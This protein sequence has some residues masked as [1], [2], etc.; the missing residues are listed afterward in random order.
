MEENRSLTFSDQE[1]FDT[2]LTSF[3]SKVKEYT[4]FEFAL[5]SSINSLIDKDF[6]INEMSS[7]R[8][9][10]FQDEFKKV[11]SVKYFQ[12][13]QGTRDIKYLRNYSTTIQSW[14][15]V[16]IEIKDEYLVAELDDLTNGGTKEIA[17]IELFSVSPDDKKLVSLGAFFYWNIGYKMNNGQITKESVIRFQR[18]IDWNEE[19]FDQAADR[20][21]DLFENLKFE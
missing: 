4:P 13:N 14:K 19:D 7:S 20:A 11:L 5:E 6:S 12:T 15:G 9:R 8:F 3:K 17:E 16:V 2:D 1:F 21:S 18:I 10:D